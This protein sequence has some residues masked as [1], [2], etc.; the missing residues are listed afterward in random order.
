MTFD[1]VKRLPAYPEV[2]HEAI[3]IYLTFLSLKGVKR[4]SAMMA[5]IE[6]CVIKS[7]IKR[8]ENL[9][10]L[11]QAALDDYKEQIDMEIHQRAIDGELKAVYYKGTVVG[12]DIVKS[13]RLLEMLA[14][15]RNP[16]RY[17]DHLQVDA[18]IKAGVLVVNTTLD[19]DDWEAEYAN[20]RIDKS[21]LD[22]KGPQPT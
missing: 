6:P 5:G 4:Y 13:D 11:E 1:L 2:S 14:K 21:R 22:Y 20:V 8:D 7:I 3:K 19:P 15:A 10:A 18:N 12:H 9:L 16:E 17:K